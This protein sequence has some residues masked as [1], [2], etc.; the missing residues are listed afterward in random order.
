MTS[1]LLILVLIVGFS[2]CGPVNGAEEVADDE[3]GADWGD[4][5]QSGLQWT[6]FFEG[7]LGSRWETDPQT[8]GKETLREIRLRVE[9]D[10][11]NDMLAIG[12]KG[13]VVADAVVNEF[14]A[15]IR[16]L[17]LSFSPGKNLDV[18]LGRQVLT[19]GTGDL[20]FLNDLFPKDWVSF[21]AGR[22]TEYLKAPSN[23][24]R[25]NL[26]TTLVNI[27]FV[28]TPVFD[29]DTY[30]TGERF[31]FFS[32]L[33]GEKGAP[34]P[35]LSADEPSK[36]FANGEFAVRLFKTIGGTEYALYG[37][38]GFSKQPVAMNE[39]QMPIF[40]P[41]TSLGASL[42]RSQ[43][44]GVFNTEI[45]YYFSRDDRSG[46]NPLVP[47]DQFRLLL[48]FDR[49]VITSFN[50]GVQYYLEWTQ[51]HDRL[52]ENSL[53][54][55]FEPDEYRHLFTTRLTYRTMMDKMIWSVFVFYSP[56]D[57]DYYLRPKLSY[58]HSDQWTLDGGVSLFGGA[59]EYTFFGQLDDNSNAYARI[60]FNF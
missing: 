59:D 50:I 39:Q 4:G 19:W 10:W 57:R 25:F 44:A 53:Y 20:V 35:P 33:A 5:E 24:T 38:R 43:W 6:G 23:S 41:L 7:A 60:R 27:D 51:D 29:S 48:G 13:D 45:S 21:F 30:L 56:N 49:E 47:N 9:T 37:Y 42:R 12:F 15:E 22:D 14:S 34:D 32:P 58:R 2:A 3:W 8:G 46:T 26:Y 11:A 55:E 31:S 16:D 40:S 18:K 28:W 17:T 52:I 1:R 36:N 54:P